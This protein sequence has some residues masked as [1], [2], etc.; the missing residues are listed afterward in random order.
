MNMACTLFGLTPEE[1]LAGATRHAAR[2]L[3]L[4]DRV[5]TLGG[6]KAGRFPAL[7]HRPSGGV[8]VRVRRPPAAAAGVPGRNRRLLRRGLERLVP[9]EDFW[10]IDS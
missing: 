6:R 3:G 4:A 7:G 9:A 10:C 8:G 2:A 5:G 1:A